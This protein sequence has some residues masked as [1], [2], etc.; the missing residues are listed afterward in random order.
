M[1]TVRV[2]IERTDRI[3]LREARVKAKDIM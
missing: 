2:N 1:R 3:S